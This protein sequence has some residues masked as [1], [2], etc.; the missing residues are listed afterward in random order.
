MLEA[1]SD[2]LYVTDLWWAVCL[3]EPCLPKPI[4]RR[5][6]PFVLLLSPSP[7]PNYTDWSCLMWAKLETNQA[8]G[9][10]GRSA[11]VWAWNLINPVAQKCELASAGKVFHCSVRVGISHHIWSPHNQGDTDSKIRI[12]DCL[13]VL[14]PLVKLNTTSA[15]RFF[16]FFFFQFPAALLWY[17]T[18]ICGLHDSVSFSLSGLPLDLV[19]LRLPL[20]WTHIY[21]DSLNKVL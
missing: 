11:I 18:N 15:W 12:H 19:P 17:S 9:F 2:V 20:G 5:D 21:T 4:R 7:F 13:K 3:P 14:S 1:G 6:K 8:G 16:F 10:R